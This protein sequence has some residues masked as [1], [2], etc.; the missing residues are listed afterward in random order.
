[1]ETK[2]EPTNNTPAQA[3]SKNAVVATQR[4][5]D[6]YVQNGKL[7]LPPDYSAENALKS[8]W[9]VLQTVVDKDR[10]PALQVCDY[11]SICNALL[12]MVVQ[13]LNPI[14]KQCYFIVYGKT[15]TCQ[16]S[17]FGDVMLAQ[18]IKPGI[19]VF[20]GVVYEGDKFSYRIERGR[21]SIVHEQELGNIKAD[22]I[23]AAYCGIVDSDGVEL[24]TEV[25]TIEQIRKSWAMSKVYQPGKGTHG[26]FPDQ[27]AMRTVIRRRCK[28]IINE[29]NDALLLEAVRRQD[30]DQVDAEFED[31][32]AENANMNPISVDALPEPTIPLDLTGE[33][34]LN[35]KPEGEPVGAGA[36]G[37][38]DPY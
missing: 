31:V 11:A 3:E 14:K 34:S 27:M 19:E 32:V 13:G 21:K 4:L 26:E 12:D 10:R 29:S 23:I 28:P 20:S 1:M 36:P 9:L 16:R 38:G 25:M 15:L 17:Y 37:G 8:A 35:G 30:V 18:R 6:Q 24:G 33:L 5:I 2:P 22:K 7:I